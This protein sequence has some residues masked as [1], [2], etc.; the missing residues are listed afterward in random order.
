[1]NIFYN[2]NNNKEHVIPSSLYQDLAFCGHNERI[3]YL[4]DAIDHHLEFAKFS[5]DA[6]RISKSGIKFYNR[7]I[8]VC[9]NH[10]HEPAVTEE[11]H[12]NLSLARHLERKNK[13]YD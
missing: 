6:E 2:H 12:D 7:I 3:A 8:K 5:K 13:K 1:M 10:K 11:F 9:H 4:H